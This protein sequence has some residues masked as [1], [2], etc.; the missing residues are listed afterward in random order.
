[1][2]ITQEDDQSPHIPGHV[3]NT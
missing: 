1:M 2:I 3:H